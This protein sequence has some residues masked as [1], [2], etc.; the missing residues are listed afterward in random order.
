[1]SKATIALLIAV[2][3]FAVPSFVV[4]TVY[5]T[6]DHRVVK[7]DT[8]NFDG[9]LLSISIIC[10]MIP[11]MAALGLFMMKRGAQG[12]D[13]IVITMRFI[14]AKLKIPGFWSASIRKDRHAFSEKVKDVLAA[15]VFI[16][17]FVLLAVLFYTLV[18]LMVNDSHD[19]VNHT[20]V[21]LLNGT[22]LLEPKIVHSGLNGTRVRVYADSGD[23]AVTNDTTLYRSTGYIWTGTDETLY[24]NKPRS[25]AYTVNR[26]SSFTLTASSSNDIS[27]SYKLDDTMVYDKTLNK[28]FELSFNATQTSSFILNLSCPGNDPIQITYHAELRPTR[29]AGYVF[30]SFKN[31]ASVFV[32]SGEYLVV[33]RSSQHVTE[34]EYIDVDIQTADMLADLWFDYEWDMYSTALYYSSLFMI[35]LVLFSICL[36]GFHSGE[37]T[38]SSSEANKAHNVEKIYGFFNVSMAFL[39]PMIIFTVGFISASDEVE[40]MVNGNSVLNSTITSYSGRQVIIPL[41]GTQQQGVS[42]T[43]PSSNVMISA[44]KDLPTIYSNVSIDCNPGSVTPFSGYSNS[45]FISEGYSLEWDFETINSADL[46]LIFLPRGVFVYKED[47]IMSSKHE[48]TVNETG[49]YTLGIMNHLGSGSVSVTFHSLILKARKYDFSN[50]AVWS[51]KSSFEAEKLD[52]SVKFIVI[53]PAKSNITT[54]EVKVSVIDFDD[55]LNAV[56]DA[57]EVLMVLAIIFTIVWVIVHLVM[58]VDLGGYMKCCYKSAGETESS[59]GDGEKQSLISGSK[60]QTPGGTTDAPVYSA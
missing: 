6:Y 57:E 18:G 7:G 54:E 15:T 39:M 23:Y 13:G 44:V 28:T 53:E 42:F 32:K 45:F 52:D 55:R 56:M 1:M 17:I 37:F 19:N 46:Q 26:G 49:V 33:D 25:F 40:R 20:T 12:K 5:F 59:S 27:L 2:T 22:I 24:P 43:T 38:E 58:A 35:I 41:N 31:Q 34:N 51:K 11:M 9:L 10:G 4:P 3:L 50:S 29:Y 60:T 48:I 47:N 8:T 14:V 21:H 36:I 30:Y 16:S